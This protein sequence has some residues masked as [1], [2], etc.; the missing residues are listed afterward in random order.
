MSNVHTSVEY[1]SEWWMH[2]QVTYTPIEVPHF[3]WSD[4][5][6]FQLYLLMIM[7]STY[8]NFLNLAKVLS[9]SQLLEAPQ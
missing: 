1:E 8:D 2:L 3:L 4:F 9:P 6:L 5:A 7:N